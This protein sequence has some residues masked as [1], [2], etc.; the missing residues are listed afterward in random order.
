QVGLQQPD[1]NGKHWWPPA[2]PIT[3]YSAMEAR[4]HSPLL[5]STTY[6]TRRDT[7][8]GNS[9]VLMREDGSIAISDTK[10]FLDFDEIEVNG[11]KRVV[12]DSGRIDLN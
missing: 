2:K 9:N 1:P 4:G 6:T 10:L 3:R 11:E 12:I 5:P 7:I 8:C